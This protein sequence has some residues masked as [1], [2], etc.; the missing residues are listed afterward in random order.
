MGT[1]Y[2]PRIVSDSLLFAVDAA[3]LKSY[4]GSGT[5]WLDLS[6]KNNHGTL[7]SGPVFVS[8]N[9]GAFL[10][11]GTDDF[12]NFGTDTSL[13][14][15]N[16]DFAISIWIK[17]P[18]SSVGEGSPSAWGPI[19]SK[20]C[21]TSAPAGSWWFAQNST[22]NN[23]ITFNGSSEAG[24]TFIMALTTP[25]LADGWHNIV[26]TRIGTN[27]YLYT[28]GVLGVTDST[29]ATNL[30]NTSAL[31]IG[32]SAIGSNKRTSMTL[33]QVNIYNRALTASEIKQNFNATRGRYGI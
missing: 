9:L 23:R 31:L 18:I 2:N 25:T 33:S 24:G 21:S 29:S 28:D 6:G 1:Y 27:S 20:G 13:I 26:I 17:T 11:D 16:S 30:S 7:N 15:G 12:A 14:I 8:G 32:N 22:N 3:N 5:S 10:F 19:L 4:P